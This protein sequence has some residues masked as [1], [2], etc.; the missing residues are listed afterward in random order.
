M[1]QITIQLHGSFGALRSKTFSA[2]DKGHA[3]AIAEAIGY[4]AEVEMPK[5]IK[6]DH[7][8]HRDNIEPRMGFGGQGLLLKT[9]QS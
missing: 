9:E 2:M 7:E 6:N 8:C 5:A 4:L 3:A 1:G